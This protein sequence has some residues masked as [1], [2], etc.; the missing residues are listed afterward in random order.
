MDEQI[1]GFR[2]VFS[3][4]TLLGIVLIAMLLLT[5]T[6]V[7]MF[8]IPIQ[9]AAVSLLPTAVLK[10][11]PASTATPVAPTATITQLPTPTSQIPPSPLPGVIGVEGYVQVN[12]TGVDGLRVRDEPGLNSKTLFVA[13]EAEVFKVTDGPR[14]IDGYMWWQL[15]SPSNGQH[16][17]WAVANFLVAIE[18]P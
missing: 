13:I 15:L 7:V 11:I 10:V 12:G 2:R 8:V 18:K 17:G 6:L 1:T 4:T 14:E 9:P 5:I 3:P 16:Q